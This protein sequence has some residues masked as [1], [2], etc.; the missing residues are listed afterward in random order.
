MIR[1]KQA[2][3]R[4][5]NGK[6][7]GSDGIQAEL[8]KI[9][10]TAVCQAL[11]NICSKIWDSEI[12]PEL[13]TKS[14][15]ICLLKNGDR[16]RYEN[17]R[18]ISLINYSNKILLDIIHQWLKPH[19]HRILSQEQAGFHEHR[20][21]VEQIFSLWHLAEK[22]VERQNKRIAQTFIDYKKTF[23]YILHAAL[24]QVL[25][26]CGIPTKLCN[27]VANIYNRVASAVKCNG[28]IGEW[29]RT[30]VGSRQWCILSPDLF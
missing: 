7:P 4:Q 30:T 24:L 22:Q 28:H 6:S 19:L 23:D 8:L 9:S 29:F 14:I 10:G 15:I 25:D 27:P 12:W 2:L 18:T 3:H 5:K 17:Y 26:H 13:L 1:S 20:S 16:S 11:F 21:N